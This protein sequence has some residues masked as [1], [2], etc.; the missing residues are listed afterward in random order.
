MLNVGAYN[1][2]S[3]TVVVVAS[4]AVDTFGFAAVEHTYR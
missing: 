4:F 3:L 1:V 2:V